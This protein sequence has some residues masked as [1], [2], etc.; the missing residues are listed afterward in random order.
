M[1]CC[2]CCGGPRQYTAVTQL[3]QNY[4]SHQDILDL[5]SY[6]F[7]GGVLKSASSAEDVALPDG[8]Q[9]H[10]GLGACPSASE[11]RTTGRVLFDGIVHVIGL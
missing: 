3:V 2:L 5:P 6:L 10:L 11:S 8:V 9:Q 1:N 4:R 7:Y